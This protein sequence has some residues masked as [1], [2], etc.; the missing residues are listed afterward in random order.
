MGLA[1][2]WAALR[3]KAR[4][5]AE[6]YAKLDVVTTC[7]T[8]R[9]DEARAASCLALLGPSTTLVADG[10]TTDSARLHQEALG[11]AVRFFAAR[12]HAVAVILSAP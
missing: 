5:A 9:E 6:A 8:A 2:E 3:H 11:I 10:L 7:T 1:S 4:A 12:A